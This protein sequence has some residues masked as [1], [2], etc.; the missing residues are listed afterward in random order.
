LANKLS[1]PKGNVSFQH[2]ISIL[3]HPNKV[4][5]YFKSCMTA[6][7]I[8]HTSHYKTTAIKMLPA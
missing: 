8:V 6:L 1:Y 3:C 5:L 2:M 7:S 4:V